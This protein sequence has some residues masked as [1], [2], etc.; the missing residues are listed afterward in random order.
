M[1]LAARRHCKFRLGY[2]EAGRRVQTVI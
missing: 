2:R 1:M